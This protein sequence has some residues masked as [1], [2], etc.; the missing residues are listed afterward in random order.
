[1]DQMW[2]LESKLFSCFWYPPVIWLDSPVAKWI[3]SVNL[4]VMESRHPSLPTLPRAFLS[5]RAQICSSSLGLYGAPCST[6]CQT[7]S[8]QAACLVDRYLTNKLFHSH[9]APK[10]KL[11]TFCFSTLWMLSKNS[12]FGYITICMGF[13]FFLLHYLQ[14]FVLKIMS[15]SK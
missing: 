5:Q 10:F 6:A 8:P 3:L 11:N 4:Q 13:F 14:Y 12:H 1:M 15:K 7:P 9:L 2:N